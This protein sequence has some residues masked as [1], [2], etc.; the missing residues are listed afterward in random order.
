MQENKDNHVAADIKRWTF[1]SK[2][3][4]IRQ[5]VTTPKFRPEPIVG[6]TRY[7]KREAPKLPGLLKEDRSFAK[8]GRKCYHVSQGDDEWR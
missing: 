4:Q 6:G 2:I 7:S 1:Y 3:H 8:Y 5:R